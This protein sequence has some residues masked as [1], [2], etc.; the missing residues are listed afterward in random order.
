MNPHTKT[1]ADMV[2]RKTFHARHFPNAIDI[3]NAM[4]EWNIYA[5]V[6]Q[7]RVNDEVLKIG[8]SCSKELAGERVYRQ[9]GNIPVYTDGKVSYPLCGNSGSEMRESCEIFE[10]RH[11]ILID[12][13]HV[14]V[15][16]WDI[17]PVFDP[18]LGTL[19][20]QGEFYE[21]Q[22]IARYYEKYHVLPPGN[23]ILQPRTLTDG[24]ALG[25]LFEGNLDTP[26]MIKT[27][28][29][30]NRS[31]NYHQLFSTEVTS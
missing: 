17:M 20:H 25:C 21:N 14:H 10:H 30:H 22:M 27:P 19:M 29:Q 3:G 31:N 23:K 8:V 26:P 6:Y 1:I 18:R 7:F 5:Y 28:K 13:N 2:P 12:I 11:K 4:T 15:D 9:M 16:I 24:K